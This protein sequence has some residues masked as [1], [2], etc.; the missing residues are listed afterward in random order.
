MD[1]RVFYGLLERVGGNGRYQAITLCVWSLLMIV[2]GSTKFFLPYLFYQTNYQ[3]PAE[4]GDCKEYV[5]SLPLD[6]RAP[7]VQD[8][9]SSLASKFGDYRCSN[10]EELDRLQSFV[11]FGG[12]VGV[13]AG[14]VVN[15]YV[16][17]R[18]LLIMTVVASIAGLGTALLGQT[19]L[20]ASIGLFVN[21]AATAIAMEMLQCYIVET[22]SEDVRGST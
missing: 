2:I 21:S 22:V 19:L 9:L 13:L 1:E 16:T 11:Y 17:K 14:A 20:I 3:C 6:E 7:F 15:E 4:H 5:C 10:S 12:V 18:M 8:G